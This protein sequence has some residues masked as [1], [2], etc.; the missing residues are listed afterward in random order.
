[1]RDRDVAM[2]VTYDEEGD[3]AYVYFVPDI[4][5]GGVDRTVPL[6]LEEIGGM[7]NVD[8]DREGQMLGIEVL[9]ASLKMPDVVM[10]LLR[11]SG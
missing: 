1:M 3:A 9:D 2:R 6:D 10:R 7:V 11:D 4:A 5:P 8:F